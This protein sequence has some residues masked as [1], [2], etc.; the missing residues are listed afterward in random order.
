MG[1]VCACPLLLRV[2]VG[3][4]GDRRP[5]LRLP[6]AEEYNERLFGGVASYEAAGDFTMEVVSKHISVKGAYAL[7]ESPATILRGATPRNYCNKRLH[8]AGRRVFHAF[9]RGESQDPQLHELIAGKKR[10]T[11]RL[12]GWICTI[13]IPHSTS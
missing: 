2:R 8:S 9:R 13:Q 12:L 4:R 1:L 6:A 10:Y 7:F 3:D 11:T 5:T